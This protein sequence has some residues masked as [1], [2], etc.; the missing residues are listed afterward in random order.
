MVE[1]FFFHLCLLCWVKT[2]KGDARPTSP[3]PPSSLFS[4]PP[5]PGHGPGRSN[6]HLLLSDRP[7]CHHPGRQVTHLWNWLSAR[8][9]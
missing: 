3:P 8:F 6:F 9:K 7:T 2:S 1:V 4:L 5:P